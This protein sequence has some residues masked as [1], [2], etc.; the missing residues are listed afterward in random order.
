MRKRLDLQSN[1][2]IWTVTTEKIEKVY[3]ICDE[4]DVDYVKTSIGLETIKL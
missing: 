1:Y 2:R 4:S 3:E